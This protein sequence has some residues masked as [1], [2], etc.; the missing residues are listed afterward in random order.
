[1]NRRPVRRLDEE[2]AVELRRKASDQGES[3][4]DFHIGRES[5]SVILDA[6]SHTAIGGPCDAHE[7]LA[8]LVMGVGV[9]VCVG[10]GFVDQQRNWLCDVG[11]Q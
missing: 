1:M 5:H 8:L 11:F 3:E 6:N 7:N 9:F 4:M 10:D 2:F